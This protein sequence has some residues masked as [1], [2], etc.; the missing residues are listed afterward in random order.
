MGVA[1]LV[2]GLIGV[3]VCWFPLIGW[4]GIGIAALAFL[5]GAVAIKK[6][7][8]GLGIAG[9]LLGLI[10]ILWGLS[11]QLHYLAEAEQA[12][13]EQDREQPAKEPREASDGPAPRETVGE[14]RL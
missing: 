1:A 4:G 12:T 3:A 13:P 9:L 7:I 6:G 10:G 8:K 11:V 2:L 5:V 14:E